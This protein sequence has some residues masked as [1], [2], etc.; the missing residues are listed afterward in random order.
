VARAISDHLRTKM[1]WK[2][3]VTPRPYCVAGKRVVE[4]GFSPF[5]IIFSS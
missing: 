2:F 5:E 4:V 1:A 3:I